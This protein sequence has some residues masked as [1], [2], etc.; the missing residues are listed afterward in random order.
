MDTCIIPDNCGS[1]IQSWLNVI[2]SS[3]HPRLKHNLITALLTK[4]D[5]KKVT[6][7]PKNIGNT[8]AIWEN[9]F[10]DD[11]NTQNNN[12]VKKV[13]PVK[14]PVPVMKYP[15]VQ[16]TQ[17]RIQNELTYEQQVELHLT[18]LNAYISIFRTN[19]VKQQWANHTLG[20]LCCIRNE[21]RYLKELEIF[22]LTAPQPIDLKQMEKLLE[23]PFDERVKA[24]GAISCVYSLDVINRATKFRFHPQTNIRKYRDDFKYIDMISTGMPKLFA[25]FRAFFPKQI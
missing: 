25:K 14:N 23:S 18:A 10:D 9:E 2:R 5:N 17:R 21:H 6:L 3:E 15:Y 1:N 11:T 16:K 7:N 22:Q 24:I 19:E 13:E 20:E 8:L 12:N 4:I